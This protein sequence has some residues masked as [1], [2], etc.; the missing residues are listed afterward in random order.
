MNLAILA[1]VI[2]T[3]T[4]TNG[5]Q[6]E[7]AKTADTARPVVVTVR[8]AGLCGKLPI[9]IAC[10]APLA[11][12]TSVARDWAWVAHN[13]ARLGAT[14]FNPD[15]V[16]IR[17]DHR[18]GFTSTIRCTPATGCQATLFALVLWGTNYPY[19]KPGPLP[20]DQVEIASRALLQAIGQRVGK[21]FTP[22]WPYAWKQ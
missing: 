13:L 15:S 7:I 5:Q 1:Q 22:A 3:F 6:L 8:R 2:A 21:G 17:A 10:V 14:P 11:I 20:L 12:D 18:L 16:L 4:F 19:L 9:R